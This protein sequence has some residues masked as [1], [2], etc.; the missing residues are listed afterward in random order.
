[1]ILI[2]GGFGYIGGNL[3]KLL[4]NS[5]YKIRVSTRNID[6]IFFNKNENLEIINIDFASKKSLNEACTGVET[7]IHLASLN[8]QE[9]S[10]NYEL[11]QK[12]NV[13]GT[14]NLLESAAKSGVKQFIYL[15]S[16][17]VYGTPLE[18]ILS[19]SSQLNPKS[20]YA[21]SKYLVENIIKE[22]SS[23][24]KIKTLIFRLS[25]AVGPPISK[26]VNCWMLFVNDISKQ[27]VQTNKIILKSN[28]SLQRDFI[29]V[30]TVSKIL[31]EALSIK[32][33]LWNFPIINMSSGI[34]YTLAE[35]ANIVHTKIEI[36]NSTKIEIEKD[37]NEIHTL[38][39]NNLIIDNKIL[40]NNTSCNIRPIENEIDDLLSQCIEWFYK[41]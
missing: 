7:I 28:P 38:K 5:H 2:T 35:V 16:V 20:P 1:M 21:K 10:Q 27:A 26:D 9:T 30:E 8:S 19:E 29:S 41:R 18:G 32:S 22:S 12:I 4:L 24:F 11:S 25:N 13:N 39:S 15:S 34:S 23:K 33:P 31:C 3:I 36:L 37:Y 6:N 40:M 14:S 17:H